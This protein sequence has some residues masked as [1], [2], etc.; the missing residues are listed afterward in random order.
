MMPR[1]TLAALAAAPL[2][3][4]ASAG[5]PG[6]EGPYGNNPS[7]VPLYWIG[8]AP[9]CTMVRI[10]EV[11]AQSEAGLREAALQVRGNAVVLVRSAMVVPD[12]RAAYRNVLVDPASYRVY[13]GV[14]V[15]LN[16]RC[17][18]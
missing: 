1:S 16:D 13:Y 2:V 6:D 14:A 8:Q 3:A 4:C 18:I 10:G 7:Q 15:R 12:T 9:R 5:V 17:S 11:Q